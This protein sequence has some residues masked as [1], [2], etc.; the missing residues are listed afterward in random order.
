[1]RRSPDPVGALVRPDILVGD[2][3]VYSWHLF[4]FGYIDLVDLGVADSFKRKGICKEELFRKLEPVIVAEVPESGRFVD[5]A[6][7]GIF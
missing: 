4:R 6:R 7:A 3:L 5:S 1:M 2:D